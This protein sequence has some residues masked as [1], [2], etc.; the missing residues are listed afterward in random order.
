MSVHCEYAA[1]F[2]EHNMLGPCHEASNSESVWD[3]FFLNEH[4]VSEDF[5][6]ERASQTQAEREAL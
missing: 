3:S 2:S 1:N 5:L 6:V 4:T